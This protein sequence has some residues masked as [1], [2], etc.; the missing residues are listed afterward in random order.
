MPT[1][2]KLPHRVVATQKAVKALRDSQAGPQRHKCAACA[3]EQGIA[4][5][6][7]RATAEIEKQIAA[8]GR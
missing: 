8:T 4:D 2:C 7:R 6:M 1:P 5:G 3:Y